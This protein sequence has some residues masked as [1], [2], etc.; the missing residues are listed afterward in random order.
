M[1]SGLLLEHTHQLRPSPLVDWVGGGSGEDEDAGQVGRAPAGSLSLISKSLELPS[2]LSHPSLRLQ[3][4]P[5]EPSCSRLGHIWASDGDSARR[6]YLHLETY[7]PQ[8]TT[9]EG[10]PRCQDFFQI[11]PASRPLTCN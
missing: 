3:C 6:T 10:P 2:V 5:M 9:S 11:L 1:P 8:L 7:S 4:S